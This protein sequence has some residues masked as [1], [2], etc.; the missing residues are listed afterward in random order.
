MQ[1]TVLFSSEIFVDQLKDGGGIGKR[2]LVSFQLSRIG[3]NLNAKLSSLQ[4]PFFLYHWS[5]NS[6]EYLQLKESQHLLLSFDEFPIRL[7]S[8]I[9]EYQN[10]S[11]SKRDPKST[12]YSIRIQSS[13]KL[14]KLVIV[15]E[16]SFRT[17]EIVSLAL[18]P[19]SEELLKEHVHS[20]IYQL[21]EQNKQLFNQVSSLTQ[22]LKDSNERQRE[23][24]SGMNE[25][26]EELKNQISSLQTQLVTGDLQLKEEQENLE[27]MKQERDFLQVERNTFLKGKNDLEEELKKTNGQIEILIELK[28][29]KEEK[30]KE[31]E[32]LKKTISTVQSSYDKQISI[33][34]ELTE[35]KKELQN[36]IERLES[37]LSDATYIKES[38]ERIKRQFEH[39]QNE[40]GLMQRE[41]E[42][43]TKSK[44][45]FVNF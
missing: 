1:E 5:I 19:A 10:E 3:S 31:I 44:F 22:Q 43:Q 38:Y 14:Y 37:S 8:L 28:K 33:S 11:C 7:G 23:V 24:E 9:K 34:T 39:L 42:N 40:K 6:E 21:Q 35:S 32:K 17:L 26:I 41:L 45:C 16:N 29:E 27:R 12:S 2:L 18:L 36:K 15:E 30:E 13:D 25:T 4:D 20:V